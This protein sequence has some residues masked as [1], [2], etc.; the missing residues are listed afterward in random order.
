MF[1]SKKDYND[2][3]V[4]QLSARKDL[5]IKA[6]DLFSGCGGMSLGFESVGIISN[7]IDS[8][9]SAV[10]T[11]NRNLNGDAKCSKLDLE[12][13]Y[14]PSDILVAGPPCQ[15]YSVAGKRLGQ[16]DI[17]NGMP[18]VLDALRKQKPKVVVVENVKGLLKE[19]TYVSSLLDKMEHLGYKANLEVLNARNFG[20]PQN[21]ERLFIVGVKGKS[22]F[23]FPEPYG[24]VVSA[25]VAIGR[26]RS[27]VPKGT[28]TLT[29]NIDKYILKYEV[30]SKCK[31]P[32][33]LHL[34][35][36]SRTITCRNLSGSTGDMMRVKLKSGIRR[37]LSVKEAAALQ[38]FP[39][40]FRFS[41]TQAEAYKQIGNAVPPMLGRA[42]AKEIISQFFS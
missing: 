38:S 25:G 19:K 20:V 16:K 31:R 32:R 21:R 28:K 27:S 24:D 14:N 2:F 41:G 35:S 15:P 29:K 26:I 1:K 9:S 37:T 33:D 5:G 3:L 36:P 40:W 12:F 30:A 34:D 17:R 4:E 10:K 8:N 42:I 18:M 11:F 13:D 22:K 39:S 7:G 6:M 23:K